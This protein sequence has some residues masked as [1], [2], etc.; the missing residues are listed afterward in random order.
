MENIITGIFS[1]AVIGSW[2]L[3]VIEG[4]AIWL[5]FP[6]FFRIGVKVYTAQGRSINID[7]FEIGEV[8]TTSHA[9]FKRINENSC[10]FRYQESPFKIH[11][12]FP[13]KGE[14]LR[15]DSGLSV[16]WRVPLGSTLFFLLWLTP[17]VL[18]GIISLFHL[19]IANGLFA[20]IVGIG[21]ILFM[22]A[23]SMPLENSR[24]QIALSELTIS[25]ENNLPAHQLN[26]VH[27]PL[28]KIL[29][30]Q[31]GQ[32][33]SREISKKHIQDGEHIIKSFIGEKHFSFSKKDFDESQIH[34]PADW[35]CVAITQSS[36]ILTELDILH[37]PL[38]VKRIPFQEI[39]SAKFEKRWFNTDKIIIEFKSKRI[40]ALD[41]N[42]LFRN[43][44]Q[45]FCSIFKKE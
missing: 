12:P 19:D 16:I 22:I 9:K 31:A 4:I 13:V 21:F 18:G 15:N 6:F 29:D 34:F 1:I 11:T 17:W 20:I 35:Y 45:A 33:L 3:S 38:N 36:L 7:K 24:A 5:F 10:L 14:I 41:V 23:I 30:T 42:H 27:I 44:I 2:L 43:Q 25:A 39:S 40:L 37:R 32:T 8:Y 26:N 28:P